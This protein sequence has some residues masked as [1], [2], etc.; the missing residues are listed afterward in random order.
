MTV[1]NEE[2]RTAIRRIEAKAASALATQPSGDQECYRHLVRR[3]REIGDIAGAFFT[4]VAIAA[5]IWA[6]AALTPSQMSAE[7]ERQ[8]AEMEAGR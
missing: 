1:E 3:M 6:Y 7:C 4:A 5:A 2:L 8:Y